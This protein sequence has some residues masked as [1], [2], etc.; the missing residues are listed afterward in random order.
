MASLQR[1][2]DA[3]TARQADLAHASGV[4]ALNAGNEG[5]EAAKTAA[6]AGASTTFADN[7]GQIGARLAAATRRC[8]EMEDRIDELEGEQ[9]LAN[10][11][12]PCGWWA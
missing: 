7:D 5:S 1:Q 2:L 12:K 11:G 4:A 6:P 9:L 3:L 10:Q 8:A